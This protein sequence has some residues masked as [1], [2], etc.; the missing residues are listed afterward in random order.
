MRDIPGNVYDRYK[1]RDFHG[2][3]RPREVDLFHKR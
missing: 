2:P 3:S 1:P